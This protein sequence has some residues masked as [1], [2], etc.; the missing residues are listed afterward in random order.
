SVATTPR[1]GFAGTTGGSFGCWGVEF[2]A[3]PARTASPAQAASKHAASVP[4]RGPARG[5]ARTAC[6]ASPDTE[7]DTTAERRPSTSGAPGG[8]GPPGPPHRRAAPRA[9]PRQP[10]LDRPARTAQLGG[11]RRP[12]TAF[13]L[14]QE[15]RQAQ[16]LRESVDFLVDGPAQVA[17]SGSAGGVFR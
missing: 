15:E 6:P 4:A 8:S 7:R 5:M 12:A 17:G 10:C 11:R 2:L 13:D 14:A 9:G 16:F 1:S 3:G